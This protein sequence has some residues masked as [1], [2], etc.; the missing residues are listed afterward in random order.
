MNEYLIKVTT[1]QSLKTV[2]K[3]IEKKFKLKDG[4][5]NNKQKKYIGATYVYQLPE[6]GDNRQGLDSNTECLRNRLN[7]ISNK[8]GYMSFNY[9][10]D[11]EAVIRLTNDSDTCELPNMLIANKLNGNDAITMY[12]KG[13]EF[14]IN[15]YSIELLS[16][17]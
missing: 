15:D 3:H 12:E 5:Y 7:N 8:T 2:T 11:K 1:K 9:G 13:F 6:R 10:E 16:D 14:T 4:A 17:Y